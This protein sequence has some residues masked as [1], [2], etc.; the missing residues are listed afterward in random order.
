MFTNI[1]GE[2]KTP[3]SSNKW[4]LCRVDNVLTKQSMF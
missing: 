3:R 2:F 4:K 1:K